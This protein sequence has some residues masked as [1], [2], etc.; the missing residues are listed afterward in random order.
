MA[1]EKTREVLRQELSLDSLL[2]HIT[3]CQHSV[4]IKN[5]CINCGETVDKQTRP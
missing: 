5:E 2:H 3:T 1:F 4:V